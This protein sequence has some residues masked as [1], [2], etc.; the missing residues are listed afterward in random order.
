MLLPPVDPSRWTPPSDLVE[1]Y[2]ISEFLA[3]TRT[4]DMAS[5]YE[6][7]RHE[8]EW[9]YPTAHEFLGLTWP[10]AWTTVRDGVRGEPHAR[11]FAGGR[12]NL[13]WLAAERWTGSPT[14]A[15][16]W[17]DESGRHRDLSFLELAESVRAAAAGLRSL[18][19]G[20]DDVV[21]MFLPNIPEAL[22]TML[23]T[24]SIGAIVA[25]A[26][27]GY[28]AEPL[29]ERLR[30]AG[31]KLLITADG[32]VRRTRRVDLLHT[33]L[34]ATGLAPTVA[35]VVVVPHLQDC[36]RK[37]RDTVG[38]ADMLASGPQPEPPLLAGDTPWLLAFTSGSTGRPKGAV[39]THGGLGYSMGVEL[40]LSLDIGPGDRVLWPADMG[41]LAGPLLG[42]GPLTLGATTVLFDGAI[43]HPGPD[44]IWQLID[45]HQV[46]HYGLSPTTARMLRA[47][48]ERRLE[49]YD[50][51]SLRILASSGEPLTES[52]WTWLH[53]NVGR[54]RRPIINFTGGTEVGGMLL[55]CYPNVPVAAARFSGP[56]LGIDADV[57]DD[58]G[59][60]VLNEMGEL[61]IR[62]SWPH[63]TRGLW[64]EP[65]RYLESYWSTMPGCWVQGDRAA[66]FADGSF[67]VPG[68]SDDVLKIAGKRVG[69]AELESI[70][71]EL[72][73][74]VSAAAVGLPHV[75]KGEMAVIVLV[76]DLDDA[77][78]PAL[79]EKV[80]DQIAGVF[81]KPMRPAA[82][83]VVDELPVS[84]SGKV[85]RRAVRAWLSEDDPGD[86][87]TLANPGAQ[88]TVTAAR[89][90]LE[91]ILTSDIPSKK[92]NP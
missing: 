69:P 2:R 77:E 90:Q 44:R 3:A 29:A 82:V 88:Q 55:T 91:A 6:R 60:P 68:R 5:L 28:G 76:A 15:V 62:R 1:S 66:R 34:S 10:A 42:I 84:R 39:H 40:G 31:A 36:Q 51:P 11:W 48:G 80:S 54:G 92:A 25:P 13:A 72:P 86:L 9:F 37:G 56:A 33:A 50:L 64:Q 81:G 22:I 12:T 17:E 79:A 8:P 73:G 23:A 21:G 83:L 47:A 59:K 20:P 26:F 46:T 45:T 7:A 14:P 4:P 52:T 78:R 19:I 87:S 53:T 85:L 57:V 32:T 71:L 30:L 65:E 74:V 27:S 70:A 49:P 38:W 89:I 63:M 75:T 35:S 58:S 16:I 18:G 67:V 24:A 43:D 61:V 41:W